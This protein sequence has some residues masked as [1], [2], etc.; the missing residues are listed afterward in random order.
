MPN[1]VT[2]ASYAF[3][4]T[5]LL[6]VGLLMLVSPTGFLKLQAWFTRTTK[7]LRPASE[8]KAELQLRLAGFLIT[9]IALIV[10]KSI[11]HSIFKDPLSLSL[12]LRHGHT[13]ISAANW[14]ALGAGLVMVAGGLQ[15]MAKPGSLLRWAASRAHH[16]AF[17]PSEGARAM[18]GARVAG[19]LALVVGL[20]A[21]GLWATSID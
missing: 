16:V 5:V 11:F 9:A 1:W 7:W 17:D 6:C 12:S 20:F 19:A 3:W 18:L 14:Y 21:I 10:L 13:R 8:L 4:A 15:V 2:S